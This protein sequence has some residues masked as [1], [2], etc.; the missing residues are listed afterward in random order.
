MLRAFSVA[1]LSLLLLGAERSWVAVKG[2]ALI[3]GSPHGIVLL[4]DGRTLD[5]L[6]MTEGF[7]KRGFKRNEQL[8]YDVSTRRFTSMHEFRADFGSVQS[9]TATLFDRR[10]YD[11]SEGRLRDYGSYT[12]DHSLSGVDEVLEQRRT[13]VTFDSGMNAASGVDDNCPWVDNP[14]QEDWAGVATPVPDGIGNHCQCGDVTDDGAVNGSDRQLLREAL[15]EITTLGPTALDK[16]TAAGVPGDCDV[17]SV[18]VITRALA[19]LDPGV[20]QICLADQP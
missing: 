13:L 11:S 7:W 19:S 3:S 18:A 2:S 15:A 12:S 8:I 17:L 5:T 20:A 9:D 4:P 1:L 10:V 14:F 16:C 6:A